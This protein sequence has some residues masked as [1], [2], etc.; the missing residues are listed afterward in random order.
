MAEIAE[1]SAPGSRIV[2]NYQTTSMPVLVMRRVMRLVLRLSR[3]PDPLA[4]EPWRSLWSPDRLRSMLND[5]GFAVRS[6]S[7]LLALSDGL[8]LSSDNNG[9]LRN[10]RVA[11]AV[12]R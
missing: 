8:D 1:L 2:V 6:D 7:D 11:V 3:V 12:R 4:G 5:N 9:S 10:G